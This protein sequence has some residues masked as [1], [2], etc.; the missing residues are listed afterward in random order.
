MKSGFV[1]RVSNYWDLKEVGGD[2]TSCLSLKE[3]N[4]NEC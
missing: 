1:G 4:K 2:K 3:I